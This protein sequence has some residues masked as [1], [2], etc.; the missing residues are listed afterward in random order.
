VDKVSEAMRLCADN[1]PPNKINFC[2]RIVAFLQQ[3]S[4]TGRLLTKVALF[5]KES[6][7]DEFKEIEKEV[8]NFHDFNDIAEHFFVLTFFGEIPVEAEEK[9]RSCGSIVFVSAVNSLKIH[10]SGAVGVGMIGNVRFE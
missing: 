3:T 7:P 9:L 4:S 2:G 5:D 6:S 10:R 8:K 1:K